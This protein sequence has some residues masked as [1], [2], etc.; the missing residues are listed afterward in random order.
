MAAAHS[1]LK[2]Q[3][4]RNPPWK[5]GISKAANR[6]KAPAG[7]KTPSAPTPHVQGP[8]TPGKPGSEVAGRGVRIRV[9]GR[10]RDMIQAELGNLGRLESVLRCLAHSMEYQSSGDPESPYY[11][12]IAEVACDLLKRSL[13]DLDVLYDGYLPNPL[14]A[15]RRIE[16]L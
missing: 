15:G 4:G 12:D 14:L 7:R 2:A 1:T 5:T 9:G 8:A 6:A 10:L 16:R 11:P 3:S 13:V